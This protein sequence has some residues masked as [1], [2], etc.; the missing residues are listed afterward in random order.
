MFIPGCS[1]GTAAGAAIDEWRGGVHLIGVDAPW[2][3]DAGT[4]R[5]RRPDRHRALD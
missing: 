1:A 5:L 4:G 2:R 3:W